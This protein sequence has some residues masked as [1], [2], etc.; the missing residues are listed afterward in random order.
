MRDPRWGRGQETPG[1]DP[2]LT[3]QYAQ[4]LV[5]GLQEGED[6]KRI[7]IS[8]CCKHFYAYDLEFWGGIDRH[9]FDA[10][11]NAQDET[12]TYFPAFH[13]CVKNARVSSLM[14]SYNSVNGVPS[15]ANKRIMTD[16]ARVA[17]G[18]DGYIT[19][20][21]GA[22]QD[23]PEDHKYDSEYEA[24]R[25]TLTA[26]MDTDCGTFMERFMPGSLAQGLTKESQ[27]DR[28]LEHL[29]GVQI[30]LGMFDTADQ[31]YLKYT[32]AEKVNT[33]EHQQLALEAARQ[34][35]V[36]LKNDGGVL[37]LNAKALS[38]VAM[39]GPSADATTLLQAN[40]QGVAPYLI[41]VNA[42]VKQYVNTSLDLGCPNQACDTTTNFPDAA[43]AAGKADATVIV[44]GLSMTQEREGV[45]RTD[46]ALPGH[47]AELVALVAAAAK[48]PVIA[49]V[50]AGGSLDLSPL[51][52]NKN[53]S[54]VLWCG[55]PGQSGG[56]A[57]AEVIFGDVNPSGRL[58][59]TQYPANY[60]DGLSM[61]DMGMRPN[62]SSNNTGRT[63]RFYTGEPVYTFGEGMS[64]TSFET[65]AVASA[66]TV[67]A[68]VVSAETSAANQ[69]KDFTPTATSQV[70]ATVSV[71]VR[72]SGSVAGQKPVLLFAKPPSPGVGGA[73]LKFLVGF[74]RIDLKPSESTTVT[75]P[76]YYTAFSLANTAGDHAAASGNW[77]FAVD[78]ND[79]ATVSI[80][81]Q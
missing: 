38:T 30:R 79:T 33:P 71:T 57:V 19:S 31:P 74:E 15:C 56:Q 62:A 18:F 58:P 81:V 42:G 32:Y 27:V 6:P 46:I 13:A 2:H 68:W 24:I 52:D 43:K 44:L 45:D 40:Y 55:Y 23:I 16:Y 50:V 73:P 8:S 49:V 65:T 64:Y 11:V 72:N 26:G 35:T 25:D 59:H 77:V 60:L 37:P 69:A 10:I 76:L 53:V 9:H 20:D 1:E 51:K 17:W 80:K 14:C 3:S 39:V 41:S 5:T 48:G 36:L 12:D 7:K 63:Y 61:F 75:F 21:C 67:D 22:V 28:A 29:F 4:Q 54:A 70:L 78:Y 34:G 66:A 47:Q